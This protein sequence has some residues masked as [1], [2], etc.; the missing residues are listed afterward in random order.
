[1]QKDK[2]IFD[3][4][5]AARIC[6]K[7]QKNITFLII[8]KNA[9]SKEEFNSIK[10]KILKKLGLMRNYKL[11][12]QKKIDKYDINENVIMTGFTLDINKFYEITDILCFPNHIEAT[13]RPVFEAAKHEVTSIVAL[14]KPQNDIVIENYTGICVPPHSPEILAKQ[15]IN[16]ANDM[17]FRTKLGKNARIHCEKL[18]DIN[19]TSRKVLELYEKV[20]IQ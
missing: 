4:I 9:H 3:F 13:G 2:G 8:G 18:F 12:I 10:G 14:T 5:E 15:I 7:K 6:L 19:Q 17:K 16:L 20:L 11:E 1:M